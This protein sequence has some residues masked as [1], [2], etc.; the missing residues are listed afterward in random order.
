MRKRRI[1]IATVLWA[2]TGMAS[3]NPYIERDPSIERGAAEQLA[4][5]FGGLRGAITAADTSRL[6]PAR[7]DPVVTQAV[8]R[9]S[10][11]ATSRAMTP[12]AWLRAKEREEMRSQPVSK[13][14]NPQ[15]VEIPAV[16]SLPETA[17]TIPSYPGRTVRVVYLNNAPM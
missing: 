1:L 4:K 17:P 15:S 8:L 5:E 12:G 7:I 10:K 2:V 9:P 6:A 14:L 3:A 13:K 11:A 16:V